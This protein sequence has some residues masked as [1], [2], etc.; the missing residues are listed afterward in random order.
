MST[1]ISS[2][3]SGKKAAPKAPPRRRPAGP[4]AATQPAPA[5]A[6]KPVADEPDTESSASQPIQASTGVLLTPS[7]SQQ[8]PVR[9]STEIQH[10]RFADTVTTTQRNSQPEPSSHVQSTTTSPTAQP[11]KISTGR[12]SHVTST[13]P[14]G[15]T[16]PLAQSGPQHQEPVL[17]QDPVLGHTHVRGGTP[18]PAYSPDTEPVAPDNATPA[19]NGTLLTNVTGPPESTIRNE[20]PTPANLAVQEMA[21]EAANAN[22]ESDTPVAS[23]SSTVTRPA[24]R[25]RQ[26]DS[27]A[28]PRPRKAPK[29]NSTRSSATVQFQLEDDVVPGPSQTPRRPPVA[30]MLS[31]AQEPTEDVT[32]S[33]A[34]NAE[35]QPDDAA[36]TPKK[37]P[38]KRK[39]RKVKTPARVDEE[40]LVE[41][42]E[43]EQPVP[44]PKKPR[45][46]R[47]KAP[48]KPRAKKARP[49]QDGEGEVQDG[50]KIDE[51]E[52]ESD[53]E[54]HEIDPEALSMYTITKQKRYGKI[55]EREKKMAEIDW[56]EVKRKRR[57]EAE[58][59]AAG[60][61]QALNTQREAGASGS[62][63]D[64]EAGAGTDG[65]DNATT[66]A[67]EGGLGFRVVNGEIVEDEETLQIDRRAQAQ[68]EIAM[69]APIEEENDLTRFHNR[70]TYMNDRKRDEKD[71]VPLWKS[72]SD[73]WS[74][75]ETGRF[76]DALKNWGTDFMIISQL[77]P[78]KT[79][80]QIKKKFNR[81]E[82]IDPE[83]VNAALLG[84]DPVSMDLKGYALAAN[85]DIAEF[86]KFDSL[87]HAQS[88]ISESMKDKEEAMRIAVKE[89]EETE[90]QR[91]VHEA[92]KKKGR[93]G[94]EER[95][96][97]QQAKKRAKAMGMAWGDGGFG[98]AADDEASA[99]A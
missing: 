47:Q 32:M 44:K 30:R 37:A 72:K 64:A 27:A 45:K 16:P 70:A 78:P 21:V 51:E 94:A 4:P 63:E 50:A 14:N 59:I 88:L 56:D 90:R 61:G 66:R 58:S 39:P 7:L 26:T 71:R 93:E 42:Q 68:A 8:S 10:V 84:K 18:P 87:E 60:N 12:T 85:L 17:S 15:S 28:K 13:V 9:Q 76:Y 3:T 83:R 25:A 89:A 74:E 1:L 49:E 19:E 62:T 43:G 5:V 23:S 99:E 33:D 55:S 2:A 92:G 97:L 52:E 69:Q 24:K 73:P 77:F 95:K 38:T 35:V 86:N 34:A 57:E 31:T 81:E 48:P 29:R 80:A 11:V 41:G 22:V 75:D 40:E 20:E 6:S 36:I 96:R 67:V 65:Q 91:A 79:R 82:R 98:G 53:P 46:P 54:L